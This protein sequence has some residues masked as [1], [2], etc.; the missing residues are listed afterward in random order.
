MTPEVWGWVADAVLILHF[1]FVVFVVGGLLT[2]IVGNV[3]GWVFTNQLWFRALH[4]LAILI[5]VLESWLGIICPL[6]AL[7]N[8][9][10]VATGADGY[11][12]SFIEHWLGSVLF[13]D[14]PP[15]VFV[16]AYTCFGLLVLL[17][18]WKFPPKKRIDH[19]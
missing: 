19:V 7:E 8:H 1:A 4:L 14:L 18:W 17:T 12:T 10:R 11:A 9:A 16:A 13:F 15:W 2:I 5:V 6:T 3:F